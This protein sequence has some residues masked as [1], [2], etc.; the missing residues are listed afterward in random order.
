MV[1]RWEPAPGLDSSSHRSYNPSTRI[2]SSNCI[3]ALAWREQTWVRAS[4]PISIEAAPIRSEGLTIH[5]GWDTAALDTCLARRATVLAVRAACSSE[6]EQMCPPWKS[7][8]ATSTISL[9]SKSDKNDSNSQLD[10][11]VP[12][13][14][15]IALHAAIPS[16]VVIA[17]VSEAVN[18]SALAKV[19]S[20]EYML[21][22]CFSLCLMAGPRRDSKCLDRFQSTPSD[23]R[24]PRFALPSP[25][26]LYSTRLTAEPPRSRER[27]ACAC[28]RTSEARLGCRAYRYLWWWSSSAAAEP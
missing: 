2:S 16:C 11:P 25:P 22:Q 5:P 8:Q 6:G 23:S 13:C 26:V 12:S 19:R 21:D 1:A 7:P 17:A 10:D 28:H 24:H 15:K 14:V 3:V 9:G 27:H 18:S 20:I 4:A